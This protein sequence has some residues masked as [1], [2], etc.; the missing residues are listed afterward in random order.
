MQSLDGQ[1]LIIQPIINVNVKQELPSLIIQHPENFQLNSNQ[2]HIIQSS[3]I[4]A[5][6]LIESQTNSQ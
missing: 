1:N 2:L 5:T 6:C 4:L 3:P